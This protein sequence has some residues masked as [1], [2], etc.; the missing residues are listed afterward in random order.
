MNSM[1]PSS[2]TAIPVVPPNPAEPGSEL[3]EWHRRDFLEVNAVDTAPGE[4]RAM[5]RARLPLWE[6]GHLRDSA[7]L[8]ATELTTNSVKATRLHV[9]GLRLPPIRVWL[10]GSDAKAAVAVWDDAPTRPVPR[11]ADL[12]DETGRGLAFVESLSSE[13]KFWFP[14]APFTGKV[15]MAVISQP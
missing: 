7:V 12:W 14:A 9:A 1:I 5:I 8:V 3:V 15:T 11:E 13:W 4:V 6:L 10:L 2:L